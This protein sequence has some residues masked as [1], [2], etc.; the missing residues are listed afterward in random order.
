MDLDSWYIIGTSES[1]AYERAECCPYAG[2]FMLGN[3]ILDT[4][5][6]V[7]AVHNAHVKP[8]IL[9]RSVIETSGWI[10]CS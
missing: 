2:F 9:K 4:I 6:S 5:L 3:S 8:R 10:L 7:F 1:H